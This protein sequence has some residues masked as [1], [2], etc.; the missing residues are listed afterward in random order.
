[1]RQ[2]LG[3]AAARDQHPLV[4]WSAMIL[5]SNVALLKTYAR[6]VPVALDGKPYIP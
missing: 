3:H 4:R 1:M 2:R 5:E 6:L